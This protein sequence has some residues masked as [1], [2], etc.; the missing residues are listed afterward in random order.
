MSQKSQGIKAYRAACLFESQDS[1]E[2]RI[3]YA[4]MYR[5]QKKIK[6]A[7][8][9]A[10]TVIFCGMSVTSILA[11]SKGY[12]KVYTKWVQETEVEIEEPDDEEEERISYEEKMGVLE[13]DK[14]EMI[15]KINLKR[16]MR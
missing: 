1:L 8:V 11:V 2:Q 15:K 10:M 16:W 14:S 13:N 9:I 5:K 7:A 12:Q 4:M 6:Y 3:Y